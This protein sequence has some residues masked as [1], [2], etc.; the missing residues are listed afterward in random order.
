MLFSIEGEGN[1]FLRAGETVDYYSSSE[2]QSRNE[3]I[4][5]SYLSVILLQIYLL[6]I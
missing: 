1:I 3:I 2:K 5:M 4:C 6:D